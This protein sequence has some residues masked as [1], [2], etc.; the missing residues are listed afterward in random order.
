MSQTKVSVLLELKD[1]LAGGLAVVEAQMGAVTASVA[2]LDERLSAL[3]AQFATVSAAG[4]ETGGVLKEAL[5]QGISFGIVNQLTDRLLRLPGLLADAF[6]A[7]IDEGV[8]FNA[9][10]ESAQLAISAIQLQFRGGELRG[11][12][13]A[14]VVADGVVAQLRKKAETTNATF[15]SILEAY[16]ANAGQLFAA[17]VRD[18]EKQVDLMG[19]LV[20]AISSVVQGPGQLVQ[21]TRAILSA[22]IDRTAQAARIFGIEN[23]DIEKAKAA[24]RVYEYL[25]EK[26]GV[27]REVG[28]RGAKT[29]SVAVDNAREAYT[30]LL[31]EVTKPVF[32]VLRDAALSLQGILS[33]SDF[34]AQFAGMGEQLRTLASYAVQ[35]GLALVQLAPTLIQVGTALAGIAA[36][37]GTAAIGA[38]LSEMVVAAGGLQGVISSLTSVVGSFL[39]ALG[40]AGA[41]IGAATAA[42]IGLQIATAGMEARARSLLAA[43]NASVGAKNALA[44]ELGNADTDEKKEAVRTKLMGERVRLLEEVTQLR[45]EGFAEDSEE[46][47]GAQASLKAMTARLGA[48]DR[49][50]GAQVRE[51]RAA[52]DAA[53]AAKSGAEL[54]EALESRRTD[55]LN[56]FEKAAE[57]RTKAEQARGELASELGAKQLSTAEAILRARQIV[58]SQGLAAKES[59]SGRIRTDGL[60]REIL[61]LREKRAL[62][63]DQSNRPRTLAGELAGFNP[64]RAA[65]EARD[66]TAQITAKERELGAV[67]KENATAEANS[68]FARLAAMG[69]TQGAAKAAVDYLKAQTEAEKAEKEGVDL[70]LAQRKFNLQVRI[71]EQKAAGIKH[72]KEEL[73]LARLNAREVVNKE[74]PNATEAQRAALAERRAKAEWDAAKAKGAGAAADKQARADEL[75]SEAGRQAALARV[76]NQIDDLRANPFR[77]EASKQEEML[78]LYARERQILDA[79]VQ[80]LRAYIEAKREDPKAAST[81]K[82]YTKEL[83]QQQKLLMANSRAVRSTT[84]TGQ[85]ATE[86]SNLENRWGSLSKSIAGGITGVIGTAI[87]GL[88][89][90]ITGLITGTQSWG[91]AFAQAGQSIIG[92]IVKIFIEQ[93]VGMQLVSAVRRLLGTAETG[94]AA[95]QAQIASSLW[96][97]PAF[98]ASVASYGGAAVAGLAGITSGL[99]IAQGLAA[100]PGFKLGG[101][102]GDGDPNEIAGFVHRKEIVFNEQDVLRIGKGN[103]LAMRENVRPLSSTVGATPRAAVPLSAGVGGGA[104]GSSRGARGAVAT[105]KFSFAVLR[106]RSELA[107][108]LES[109]RGRG[110]VVRII[111]ANRYKFG[112]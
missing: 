54:T 30:G 10:L 29:F 104:A 79:N 21:E 100:V 90:S 85:L 2:G 25:T 77:S 9:T 57:A 96:A 97:G 78:A 105:N 59:E 6:R 4:K 66:V 12:E 83:E 27:F 99:A 3:S 8:R 95:A 23:S 87:D 74:F 72:S 34:K 43:V 70:S 48:V 63:L 50:A 94:A 32:E 45:R 102:T 24:G 110:Q 56:K 62:L 88:S 38:K 101:Y 35:A 42:M 86:L 22:Q 81:V 49:L 1:Q 52:G 18:A 76:R 5:T 53:A 31:Q 106:D 75:L 103:L 80:A 15:A 37:L 93:T 39:T 20:N 65:Q 68:R 47:A 14:G 7:A 40:P 111:D 41:I 11:F 36:T 44:I 109:S 69:L 51:A 89:S 91:Q 73:E 71:N 19:V 13:E 16:Q 17:G 60:E 92:I 82:Q 26:L 67:Q 46:L 58:E 33:S 61:Q 55:A 64:I 107:S 84:F 112:I 108:Y 98:L 28:E